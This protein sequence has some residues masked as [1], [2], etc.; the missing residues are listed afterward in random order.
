[1]DMDD[2][3]KGWCA[4]F[5]RSFVAAVLALFIAAGASSATSEAPDVEELIASSMAAGRSAERFYA[6]W[7]MTMAAEPGPALPPG[8]GPI[9]L[10]P[11]VMEIHLWRDGDAYRHEA[12]MPEELLAE[13]SM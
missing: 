2:H 5:C 11:F 7:R 8:G 12:H 9:A 3:G 1:M 6:A 4:S 13:A 10:E